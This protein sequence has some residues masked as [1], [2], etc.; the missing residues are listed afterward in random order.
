MVKVDRYF[1]QNIRRTYDEETF[2]AV[3]RLFGY[4]YYL[5]Y[6]FLGGEGE[7]GRH[8]VVWPLKQ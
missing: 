2:E 5:F 3:Q 6:F 8:E 1:T 7:G 4:C